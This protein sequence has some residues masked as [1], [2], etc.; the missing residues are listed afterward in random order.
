MTFQE[1]VFLIKIKT[2]IIHVDVR[3]LHYKITTLKFSTLTDE[4]TEGSMTVTLE[5]CSGKDTQQHFQIC[6]I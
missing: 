5:G 2:Y 6:A 1:T 4:N 3:C